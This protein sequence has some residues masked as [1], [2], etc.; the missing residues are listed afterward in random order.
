MSGGWV[1]IELECFPWANESI[2]IIVSSGFHLGGGVLAPLGSWLPPLRIATNHIRNI[3]S[4]N[5]KS[6]EIGTFLLLFNTNYFQLRPPRGRKHTVLKGR[7]TSRYYSQDRSQKPPESVSAVK[8]VK[9]SRGSTPDPLVNEHY[10]ILGWY[11]TL[12]QSLPPL[13]LWLS[14]LPPLDENPKWNSGSASG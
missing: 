2:S 8:N 3:R 6:V 14:C 12:V 7:G 10:V 5:G 4:L 9:F 1:I 11:K 13:T